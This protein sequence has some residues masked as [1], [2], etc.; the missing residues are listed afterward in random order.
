MSPAGKWFVA[1]LLLVLHFA[2]HPLWSRWPIAPDLVAG[3]LILSSLQLRWG[4]AAGFGCVIGLLEASISL[5]PMGLTMLLFAL[6][7]ALVGWVRR[8]IY[9]DSDYATPVFVFCGTWLLRLTVTL[10]VVGDSS[11]GALFV[12]GAGSAALTT[13]V[14]WVAERLV[15]AVTR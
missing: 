14:C 9:S 2:L 15:S 5:G 3:G 12:H 1:A 7:G 13:A 8:L 4:R 6:T 11:A 10:F